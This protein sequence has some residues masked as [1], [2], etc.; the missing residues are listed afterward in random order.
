MAVDPWEIMVRTV[1]EGPSLKDV[2]ELCTEV[3]RLRRDKEITTCEKCLHVFPYAHLA[4]PC[5]HCE[6]ERLEALVAEYRGDGYT[7]EEDG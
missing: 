3:D 7:G 4:V 1:A 5:P 6:I 2:V